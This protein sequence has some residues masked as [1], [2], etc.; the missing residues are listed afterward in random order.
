[1][2]STASELLPTAL[3]ASLVQ[4]ASAM[5]QFFQWSTFFTYFE[6]KHSWW[7]MESKFEQREFALLDAFLLVVLHDRLYHLVSIVE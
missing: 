3:F 6:C 2:E 4:Y 1:M 5:D 7:A